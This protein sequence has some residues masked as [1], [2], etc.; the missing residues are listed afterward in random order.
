MVAATTDEVWFDRQ[1]DG[2]SVPSAGLWLLRRQTRSDSSGGFGEFQ[3]PLRDYG[4][5]DL[6][7]PDD[8]LFCLY[9]FSSLCGIMV[10]ATQYSIDALLAKYRFQFPLRDYG[11]CDACGS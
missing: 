1:L 11:C 9:S 2:V 3:F 5:W 7:T 6:A 8:D 10:A 4:C